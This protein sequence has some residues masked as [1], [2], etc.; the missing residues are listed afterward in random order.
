MQDD[1][2]VVLG[3][4]FVVG[5]VQRMAVQE[6]LLRKK[7]KKFK[8]NPHVILD[9]HTMDIVGASCRCNVT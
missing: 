9:V 6:V 2:R 5:L 3:V 1:V 8:A 7:F 4:L